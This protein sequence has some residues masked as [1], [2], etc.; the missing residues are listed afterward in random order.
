MGLGNYDLKNF[1]KLFSANEKI[2]VPFFQ[3]PYSWGKTQ[4]IQFVD[5][6]KRVHDEKRESY[7]M[8]SLF[9][10]EKGKGKTAL[11]IDGQQR[12]TSATIFVCVIRDILFASADDRVSL[13][14]T[15]Y[16]QKTDLKTR[17]P[18]YKLTLGDINLDFFKKWIQ[19]KDKPENK[20]QKLKSES[21]NDSDK[22]IYDCY[23]EYH[24]IICGWIKELDHKKQISFLIDIL[25]TLTEKFQSLTITI[26]DETE[27]FTI[28]E[29]LNDRGMD[30]TIADLLKNYLFLILHNKIDDP[31]L[32]V[33]IG[34]WDSMIVKLGDSIT[35]FFKHYWNSHNNPISEKEIYRTLKEKIKSIGEVKTFLNKIFEESEVYYYLLNPEHVY[36]KNKQIENLLNEISRLGMR[37]C[38]PLLMGAKF[39]LPVSEFTKVIDSCVGLSFR[40][41][42]VCNLHNNKLEGHYSSI[43]NNIRNGKVTKISEIRKSLKELDPTDEI[44]SEF[45]KNLTYKKNTS[46][47]YILCKIND[48]LDMGKEILGSDEITL[49]HIIPEIPNDEW[50]EF[51]KN[52]KI[53]PQEV[54]YKLYN[55]TILGKEYN[56]KASSNSFQNKLQMYK[57]SKL[58]INCK[59]QKYTIWTQEQMND[60]G[61]YLLIKSK[62]IWKI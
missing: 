26:T 2:C 44:Y 23:K 21:M 41:S 50:K 20:I 4:Y 6:L 28:F 60:W 3:R 39:K 10:I 62:E 40:Y 54:V 37:Q 14:E 24:K 33:L 53:N 22:L 43:A 51:M 48:S 32:R 58:L 29:T 34:K 12:I 35:S 59:L 49:E 57:N 13:I 25:E 5:D 11:I 7:F 38:L 15:D 18:Y 55:M 61:N 46:P 56:E 30:L 45:F 8:G 16:L 19:I 47:R 31:E 52:N 42:T 17:E 36:W 9:F 1:K 27:A